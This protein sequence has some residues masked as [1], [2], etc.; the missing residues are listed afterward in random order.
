MFS[1]A[2]V[3]IQPAPAE[4]TAATGEDIGRSRSVLLTEPAFAEAKD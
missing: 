3:S 4:L 2:G 1:P